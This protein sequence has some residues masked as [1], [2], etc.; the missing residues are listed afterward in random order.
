DADRSTA[1][2]QQGEHHTDDCA[3]GDDR[4]EEQG[5]EEPLERRLTAVEQD[6][7][8][9][10]D[11]D[12]QRHCAEQKDQG[13]PEGVPEE[14][15]RHEPFEVVQPDECAGGGESRPV[16]KGVPPGRHQ[17]IDRVCPVADDGGQQEEVYPPVAPQSCK[18][19]RG[20]TWCHVR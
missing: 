4:Q 12:S 11:T 3:G 7:E 13:V 14:T 18:E 8:E 16:E 5:A 19:A 10:G 20:S 17:W 6:R 15:V 9:Q 1:V 2:Q